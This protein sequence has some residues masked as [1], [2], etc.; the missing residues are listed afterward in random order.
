[1]NNL[2][3][4]RKALVICA[5]IDI[6]CATTTQLTSNMFPQVQGQFRSKVIYL[7]ANQTRYVDLDL[8]LDA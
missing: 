5:L 3:K 2:S 8:H 4:R 1:M 6:S 7:N